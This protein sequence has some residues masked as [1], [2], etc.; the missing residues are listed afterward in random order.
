MMGSLPWVWRAETCGGSGWCRIINTEK[1][2]KKK[3]SGLLLEWYA[4]K[5]I[6][7]LAFY[8]VLYIV[9]VLLNTE[10]SI[11]VWDFLKFSNHNFRTLNEI[12][13]IIMWFELLSAGY[14]QLFNEFNSANDSIDTEIKHW[15]HVVDHF[16]CEFNFR[17]TELQQLSFYFAAPG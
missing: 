8:F 7:F 4:L 13:I 10:R 9:Y 5:S 6:P 11:S 12:R 14:R 15:K 2:S 17:A 3:A 16:P 1:L